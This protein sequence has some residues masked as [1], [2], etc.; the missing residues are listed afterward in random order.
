MSRGGAGQS[1]D[2]SSNSLS[3]LGG[4][5]RAS[6][7]VSGLVKLGGKLGRP[8]EL[9]VSRHLSIQ[10]PPTPPSTTGTQCRTKTIRLTLPVTLVIGEHRELLRTRKIFSPFSVKLLPIHNTRICSHSYYLLLAECFV[11]YFVFCCFCCPWA[12]AK[13]WSIFHFHST[14]HRRS[15]PE[16]AECCCIVSHEG[17]VCGEKQATAGGGEWGSTHRPASHLTV[18]GR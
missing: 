2:S 11:G 3:G 1:F 14:V 9:P 12:A 18:L 15:G 13:T 7:V 8:K 6:K 17:V 5:N 4:G 16:W 10:S